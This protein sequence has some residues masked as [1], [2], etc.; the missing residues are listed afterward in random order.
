MRFC[1]IPQ[2]MEKQNLVLAYCLPPN[3][4]FGIS[5]EPCKVS[6]WDHC[7][8]QFAARFTEKLHEFYFAHKEN[9]GHDIASF[10]CKFENIIKINSKNSNFKFTKYAL[11]SSPC[12]LFL[13]ISPFWLDCYFK[14]SLLTMILRCGQNYDVNS[15]NFDAALFGTNFKESSYLI[16]TKSAVLRF[17]FG[18]TKYTGIAPVVGQT[19]VIKHGWKEEFYKLDDAKIRKRLIWPHKTRKTV[20]I[21]GVD[22]LWT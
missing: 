17:M 10:L 7:R 18:F 11:T 9:K 22:S 3:G 19:S 8:E 16:E 20:N 12:I 14:R 5:Y 6:V 1:M 2:F 13:S 15:D 4:N 21:V